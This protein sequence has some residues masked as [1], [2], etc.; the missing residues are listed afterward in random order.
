MI[1]TFGARVRHETTIQIC[2]CRHVTSHVASLGTKL[3]FLAL[4]NLGAIYT[5]GQSEQVSIDSCNFVNCSADGDSRVVSDGWAEASAMSTDD[6]DYDV[7]C[8]TGWC[9]GGIDSYAGNFGTLDEC[10]EKCSGTF[11]LFGSEPL[12]LFVTPSVLIQY[13]G[14]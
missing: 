7:Y 11:F 8:S 5:D 6:K 3:L 13:L 14:R 2:F 1:Q 4:H 9:D 10:W 12:R